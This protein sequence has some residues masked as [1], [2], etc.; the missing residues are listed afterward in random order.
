[1]GRNN[2]L[3]AIKYLEPGISFATSDVAI[4]AIPFYTAIAW[5]KTEVVGLE[6]GGEITVRAQYDFNVADADAHKCGIHFEKF[7][8]G[9]REYNYDSFVKLYGSSTYYGMYSGAVTDVTQEEANSKLLTYFKTDEFYA[10]HNS[11][12]YVYEL[13]N[14]FTPTASVGVTGSY[15]ENYDTKDVAAFNCKFF[16]PDDAKV[17]EWGIKATA[18]GTVYNFKSNNKTSRNEYTF[19]VNV[20]KA[21]N[22]SSVKAKAYIIYFDAKGDR[23]TLLSKNEVA[24]NFN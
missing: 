16:V 23:I 18:G 19:K 7:A 2:N 21:A 3:V 17:V 10:P 22:I 8:G 6:N 13:P 9:V 20:E 12:I 11:D 14:D 4:P 15:Q 1:M 5:D 24:V